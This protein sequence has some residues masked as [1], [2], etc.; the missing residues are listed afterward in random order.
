MISGKGLFA[1]RTFD[2]DE[3]IAEYRGELIPEEEGVRRDG[4][5]YKNKHNYLYFFENERRMMW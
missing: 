4:E 1:S 2:S 3:F 5:M